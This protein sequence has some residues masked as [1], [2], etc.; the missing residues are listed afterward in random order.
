MNTAHICKFMNSSFYF[1]LFAQAHGF[2]AKHM[3]EFARAASPDL[4]ES[5]ME[6]FITR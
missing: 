5:H 4:V 3:H 6:K 2:A 1:Y